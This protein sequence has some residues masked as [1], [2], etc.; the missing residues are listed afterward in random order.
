MDSRRA[1]D[2]EVFFRGSS[3]ERHDGANVFGGQR[4]EVGK[5]LIIAGALCKA[6][7][8][9]PQRYPSAFDHRLTAADVRVT[10]N[11]CE[12]VHC[13]VPKTMMIPVLGLQS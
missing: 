8:N 5:N 3:R 10:N 13:Y 1:W 7:Q 2:R 11:V 6:G 9:G 12:T 4:G